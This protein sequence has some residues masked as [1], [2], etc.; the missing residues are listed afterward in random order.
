MADV[1]MQSLRAYLSALYGHPVNVLS[2]S[3]KGAQ[4]E[5]DDLKGFG[6]GSPLFIEYEASGERRKAVLETMSPSSYG[7]D[8]FSDRAQ[9]I[10]WEHAAFNDLPRHVRSLDS[11]AFLD[12]GAIIS[13][14]AAREF[15]LLTEFVSGTGYFKDLERIRDGGRT[16]EQDRERHARAGRLPGRDPRT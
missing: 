14:G 7:H 8:H 9:A 4:E 16:E 12:T 3:S 15:F 10:L 5:G 6:Y 13:T 11:G 1:T 2:I